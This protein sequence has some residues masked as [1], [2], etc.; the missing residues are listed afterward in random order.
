MGSMNAFVWVVVAIAV[1]L[2]IVVI[3]V[4]VW[5]VRARQARLEHEEHLRSLGVAEPR[6]PG[7][8][9]DPFLPGVPQTWSN[10]TV[11]V[12]P[13]GDIESEYARLAAEPFQAPPGAPLGQ[14]VSAEPFSWTAAVSGGTD[15]ALPAVDLQQLRAPAPQPPVSLPQATASVATPPPLTR[16]PLPDLAEDLDRTTV[17]RRESPVVG[18][19]LLPDGTSL[20]LHRDN[21]VGRRPESVPGVLAVVIADPT[22]TISKTHARLSLDGDA[23]VVEDLD[24]TNGVVLIHDDGREQ[25]LDARQP[26]IATP[27]LLLGT[28]EVQI[29]TERSAQ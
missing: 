20:P 23:W 6:A 5:W 1:A 17:V 11:Q 12:T 9:A 13:L 15:D 2:V 28:L 21:V 14:P 26:V 19:L 18:Y 27:R 3:G 10:D 4:G 22:R 7:A 29:R 25:E 8:A 24:S 16:Q